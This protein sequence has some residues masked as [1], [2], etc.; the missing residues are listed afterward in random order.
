[1]HNRTNEL[2]TKKFDVISV[3]PTE[4][5]YTFYSKVTNKRYINYKLYLY[6]KDND[7]KDMLCKTYIV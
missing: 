6:N 7:I 4:S 2:V 3:I 5:C 1:M